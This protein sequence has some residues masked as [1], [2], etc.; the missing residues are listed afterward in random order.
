MDRLDVATNPLEITQ[1]A[2]GEQLLVLHGDLEGEALEC[3]MTAVNGASAHR[4]DVHVDLGAVTFFGS[5]ALRALIVAQT[6]LANDGKDL[7]IDRASYI[8]RRVLEI[9]GVASNLHL[10]DDAE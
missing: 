2:T 8:A 9:M 4:G 3:F 1:T 5:S 7:R 6:S 10:P